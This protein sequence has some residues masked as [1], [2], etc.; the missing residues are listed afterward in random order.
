MS[1]R[2]I[3]ANAAVA[4]TPTLYSHARQFE[5]LSIAQRIGAR[6]AGG[7]FEEPASAQRPAKRISASP[8]ESIQSKF[9]S[10][11]DCASPVF[12]LVAHASGCWEIRE[13]KGTKVGLFR[14][15]QAAIKY[16]RDESPHGN[17]VII[18]DLSDV[19]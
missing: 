12:H 3:S 8:C 13:D 18:D 5:L 9:R 4:L 11:S 7:G 1:S 16:A 2:S 17:F 15:R 10:L 19:E 14:T 6:G